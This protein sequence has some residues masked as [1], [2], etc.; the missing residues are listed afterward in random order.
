[1]AH[2]V[3]IVEDDP[4]QLRYLET[5]VRNLG[6]QTFT[7]PDG[8][9]A[10]EFLTSSGVHIDLMLLDLVLPKLDGFG[11]LQR[12]DA[13]RP[14]LQIIVLTMSGGVGTVVRA[15]R[16]GAT[17]FLVKPVSPER[18][19]VSI[20]NALRI[21]TLAGELSRMSRRINGELTFE[22]LV[23]ESPGMRNVVDLAKRAAGSN[24][25]VLIEGE[26][27]VGKEMIARAIQGSG[28][29]SG[30]PFVTVNCSA[31]PENLVESI[32]FGHEK[33]AF[34]GAQAKHIGKFQE[35]NGGTLF[36]DEIGELS[37]EVQAK[38]LRALQNGEI[39]PVGSRRPVN[40]DIRLVSATNRNLLQLVKDERFREDLYYRISIFP[41]FVPPLAERRE[42]IPELV[43]R[44]IAR[45]AASEGKPV[46]AIDNDAMELLV[47]FPWPGNV[48]Q[49]ENAVFRAVVLADGDRL[50]MGDFGQIAQQAMGA[51]TAARFQ[52]SITTPI[53]LPSA[54]APTA[55]R[56]IPAFETNGTIRSLKDIEDDMIRIALDRYNGHMSEIARRLGIGRSTLYR[57]IRELGLASQTAEPEEIG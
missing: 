2:S 56:V 3:L 17:D 28:D 13:I 9:Q 51:A 40:V 30:K 18:L 21:H 53:S 10:V 35:A 54:A 33:G 42:D 44:F 27:G 52:P 26:S 38:L 1:M 20:E 45:F 12:I 5:V 24:I 15:M 8:E 50:T 22:D 4:A 43:R 7:A 25:A 6:Y 39:D 11:V 19:Q 48:R 55:A 14:N 41:I 57:K 32:L 49:L 31:I 37:L 23:A 16:G 36:L 34:T 47:Q 29:R 46:T